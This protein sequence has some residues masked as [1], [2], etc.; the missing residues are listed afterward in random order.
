MNLS[1]MRTRVRQDLHDQDS[2]NY[3]WTDAELERHIDRVVKELSL[4]VPVEARSTLTTNADSRELSLASL[5]GL[6]AVEAVEYPVGQYPLA[7]VPFNLWGSTLSLLVDKLPVAD[8]DVNIYYGKLHTLDGST[9]TIP[10]HLEDLVATGAAAYAALEWASFATNR[11]N[12]GGVTAW[13]DYLTWGQDRL[14]AFARGLAQYS[15]KNA[16]RARRLYRPYEPKPSQSTDWG[17]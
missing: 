8:E 17:P 3:R 1:Q 13:R 11:V 10:T 2:N 14:A 12:L 16:L 4:A 9:S 5:D 15:R 6:V 7:Y